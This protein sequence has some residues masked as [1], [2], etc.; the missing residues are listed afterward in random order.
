MEDGMSADARRTIWN[1][2]ILA[3]ALARVARAAA[4]PEDGDSFTFCYTDTHAGSGRIAGPLTYLDKVLARRGAFLTQDF[5]KALSPAL[6]DDGHPGSW[7]L[8]GRVMQEVDGNRVAFEIDVNDIDKD[9]IAAAPLHQEQLRARFWSHDWF[10]FLRSRLTMANPPNFVFIDPPPDDARGPAYAIDAAILLDTLGVPYMVSYPV[11]A[12][13]EPINQIGRTG[14][15]LQATD[16]GG[17]VL[18]GG[19][20]ENVLLDILPDMRLLAEILGGGFHVRLPQNIDY[21]I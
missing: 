15:E 16:G 8:A 13:Q 7:V 5:F 21:V 9:L 17:G 2:F 14:L 4:E 3:R 1:Q 6:P 10:L 19:G 20:A 12:S 11:A 18:L